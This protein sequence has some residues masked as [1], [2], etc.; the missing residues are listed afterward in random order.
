MHRHLLK[1]KIHGAT[2]T[3]AE[4]HYESRLHWTIA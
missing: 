2:L 1:A 3:G 4:L